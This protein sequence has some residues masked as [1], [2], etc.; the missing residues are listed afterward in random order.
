MDKVA[1]PAY[2]FLEVKMNDVVNVNERRPLL[3]TFTDFDDLFEGLFTPR[4]V[5]RSFESNALVPAID[6]AETDSGYLI[7]AEI[8]GV[9]KED[10]NVSVQDGVL[11]I[12][13]ES[14]Y[15][16]EEKKGG[17]VVRQERRYGKFVRSMRLGKDVDSSNVKA[18]YK[19]G[20]LE[21]KLPKLEEVKPKKI[22][23]D[24]S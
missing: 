2:Y 6:V 1:Q 9:K 8:P 3:G 22:A 5:S 7:Q 18:E 24:I 13:A 10:L 17:R 21:L 11:T 12:N 20:I 23:I 15:E 16:D 4:R 14:K 19:D